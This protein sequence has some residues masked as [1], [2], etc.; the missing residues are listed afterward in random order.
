M[1]QQTFIRGIAIAAVAALIIG[2]LL[3]ALQAITF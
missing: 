1:K 3:P 2:A